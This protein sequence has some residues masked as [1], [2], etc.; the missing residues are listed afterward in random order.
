MYY[1]RPSSSRQHRYRATVD[2]NSTNTSNSSLYS[3]RVGSARGNYYHGDNG[4]YESRPVQTL[5]SLRNNFPAHTRDGRS[6]VKYCKAL[7][8][9]RPSI[10]E[11]VG[12]RA[13]DV[14]LVVKMLEDGWWESEVL[15][16]GAIGLAPSNFLKTIGI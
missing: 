5:N 16:D 3:A 14:L 2:F 13:G 10:S 4:S 7:F 6:V 9:Y 8:D 11:E 12:F 1:Q 15:R